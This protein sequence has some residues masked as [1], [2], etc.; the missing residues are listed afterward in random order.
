MLCEQDQAY[1]VGTVYFFYK[2]APVDKEGTK[3]AEVVG[4]DN[5]PNTAL[6]RNL[7][8]QLAGSDNPNIE[9][10]D[11]IANAIIDTLRV[12]YGYRHINREKEI[13]QI[14]D[15]SVVGRGSS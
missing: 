10:L 6:I 8:R 1:I 3:N 4:D 2:D 13:E 14:L 5:I 11:D 15:W 12:D 9:C 7:T